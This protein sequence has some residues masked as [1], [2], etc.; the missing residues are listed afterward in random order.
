M[1]TKILILS[2]C[3]VFS[4]ACL[5]TSSAVETIGQATMLVE[6]SPVFVLA[7]VEPSVTVEPQ[8]CAIVVAQTA[9]HLRIAADVHSSSI[10]HLPAGE[11]VQ[12]L[13]DSDLDWW[14]V[15]VGEFEGFARSNYLQSV[16][17]GQ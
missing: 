1:K 12:V 11:M 6:V 16:E 8:R 2:F 13:D 7:T 15:Q 4:L 17:C 3:L 10:T 5:G 14:R 9:L